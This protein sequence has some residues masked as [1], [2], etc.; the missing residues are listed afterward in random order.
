MPDDK[1]PQRPETTGMVKVI[2]R[3]EG[4]EADD[5]LVESLWATPVGPDLYR[6]ENSPFYA[7]GV[8]WNDIVEAR[9]IHGD[10]RLEFVRVHAKSGHATFRLAS[11]FEDGSPR[12]D[13]PDAAVQPLL[14]LGCSYEGTHPGY[15]SFDV[16]PDA[17]WN[18]VIEYLCT[19]DESEVIW[20]HADPT[21]D[22]VQEGRG[23]RG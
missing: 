10:G 4:E 12:K 2:L 23:H 15:L 21:Y 6:L 7:Y 17:D 13:V 18:A 8:S 14:D 19:L 1:S 16:P 22:E 5:V 20:E 11:V 3:H 9:D